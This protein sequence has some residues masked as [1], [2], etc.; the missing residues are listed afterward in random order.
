MNQKVQ[1]SFKEPEAEFVRHIVQRC[2]A[3]GT[4][5]APVEELGQPSARVL[6]RKALTSR[7]L[8]KVE[9]P[10]SWADQRKMLGFI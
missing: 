4:V 9:L 2:L 7:T 10:L 6:R 1:G 8:I 5:M 3:L